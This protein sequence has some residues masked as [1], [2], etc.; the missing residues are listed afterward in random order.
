MTP[1]EEQAEAARL[2]AE[3][4]EAERIAA[5]EAAKAA[6][7]GK[8]TPEQLKAENERKAREIQ[9]LREKVDRATSGYNPNDL[10][11]WDDTQLRA[12]KNAPNVAQNFKDQA[13]DIL[14]DRRVERRFK[15]EQEKQKRESFEI[16]RMEEYPETLDASSPMHARM[17][18]IAREMGLDATP[19]GLYAAARLAASELKTVRNP[20]REAQA[21]KERLEGIKA[22]SISKDRGN[23]P[24]SVAGAKSYE[25]LL[26][27]ASRQRTESAEFDATFKE[28]LKAKLGGRGLKNVNLKGDQ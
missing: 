26:V 7:A 13:D 22:A 12:I 24:V 17:Q 4:A 23:A 19:S 5:E 3:K 1:E 25:D 10:T 9:A 16:K 21:E 8:Q 6:E 2:E 11:T 18:K 15:Q 14:F 28:A 20:G 27:K